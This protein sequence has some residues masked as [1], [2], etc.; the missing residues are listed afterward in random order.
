M[1]FP[2]TQDQFFRV[3]AAYN[4][5]VWPAQAALYAMALVAVALAAVPSRRRDVVTS[6]CLAALWFWG[7]AVYHLGFFAGINPAA[8]L[9]G[10]VF[11]LQGALFLW[12]G[13]VRRQL[14]FDGPH[15][16]RGW[17]GGLVAAYALAIYPFLGLAAG[18]PAREL[19]VMGVP[20]PTTLLTLALLFSAA[21]RSPGSS[22]SSRSSG[23]PSAPALPSPSECRRTWPCRSS[24]W[25]P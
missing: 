9:F 11:L 2:F 17:F 15:G 23:P 22:W 7:G 21:G 24:A 1:R 18:H 25:S 16:W 10:A 20:C 6:A 13:V 3:F 12:A 4:E 14:T 19:P 8:R 5:A